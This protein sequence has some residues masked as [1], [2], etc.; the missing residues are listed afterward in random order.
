LI[1]LS[2]NEEALVLIFGDWDDDPPDTTNQNTSSHHAGG[3]WA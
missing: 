2:G 1:D 3:A